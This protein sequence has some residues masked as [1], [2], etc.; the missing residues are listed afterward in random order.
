MPA[1]LLTLTLC[2]W[3]QARV[4]GQPPAQGQTGSLGRSRRGAGGGV[5]WALDR[6]R[7]YG[8][9]L[10]FG[11]EVGAV[12]PWDIQRIWSRAWERGVENRYGGKRNT[13]HRGGREDA[14]FLVSILH[15]NKYAFSFTK[16]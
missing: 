3:F 8:R 12:G 2:K 14:V 11:W 6:S 5:E 16:S 1:S 13:W 15:T 4:P 7:V 9:F 10:H